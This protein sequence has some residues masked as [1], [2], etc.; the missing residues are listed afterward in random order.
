MDRIRIDTAEIAF[1]VRGVGEQVPLVPPDRWAAHD[2][3]WRRLP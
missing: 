3:T 1:E 2:P